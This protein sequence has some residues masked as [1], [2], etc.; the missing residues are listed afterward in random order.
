VSTA[1]LLFTKGAKTDR[2]WFYDMEHDGF[3]LDDKRQRTTENDILDVLACWRNRADKSFNAQRSQRF[4]DLKSKIAPLKKDRLIHQEIIH[5]LKFEEVIADDPVKARTSREN[6][7][8]ELSTLQK[9]ITPLQA[10]INQLGRY[11]WVDKKQ[12]VSN[13]YDLSA[14]RYRDIED[15]QAFYE[16]PKTT[17]ERMRILQDKSTLRSREIERLL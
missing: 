1:I 12:I 17:L 16:K 2:I 5:R 14:T 7:E 13:K 4:S 9:H 11:F 8:A 10:E 3:S 6:A 15:D